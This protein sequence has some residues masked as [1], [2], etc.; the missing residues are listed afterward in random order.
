VIAGT[1]YCNGT[2]VGISC[3][4]LN[5]VVGIDLKAAS[6][7]VDASTA[8]AL[9]D[10]VTSIQNLTHLQSLSLSG[11]GLSGPLES[12][13]P[14]LEPGLTYFEDLKHL[15]ISSN[16]R[17]TG[18]LPNSW[19]T[20]GALQT[21]DLSHTGVSG[22]LPSAYAALQQLRE[23]KAVNCSGIAGTL[24][25]TWGL[26]KLQVLEITESGITGGL[27]LEWV[28]AAALQLAW[29]A[30]VAAGATPERGYKAAAAEIA[31]VQPS[32]LG[33]QQLR[34]LDLSVSRPG[35]GG[36]TGALPGSYAA[37]ELLQVRADLVDSKIHMLLILQI[38]P[39][40]LV[41]T[42]AQVLMPS[43]FNELRALQ[44]AF[45]KGLNTCTHLL[46]PYALCTYIV[47]CMQ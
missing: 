21:L 47:Q 20:L 32:A 7:R 43:A 15:D 27:P 31:G 26:L 37:M 42:S 1:N 34:V 14:P 36:L 2:W 9:L 3:N 17:L 41:H 18:Q 39:A 46:V 10:V 45:F 16:P 35:K 24:P 12:T 4:S 19:Y 6:V 22:T 11:L 28:D 44:G 30:S 40:A 13:Q 33:L 29:Q 23:F 38:L 8:V 5:N 25:P